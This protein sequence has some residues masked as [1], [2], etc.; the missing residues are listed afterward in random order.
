MPPLPADAYA[1]ISGGIGVCDATAGCG[2]IKSLFR[3]WRRYNTS[4]PV[5]AIGSEMEGI[6]W[7][8]GTAVRAPWVVDSGG[9]QARPVAGVPAPCETKC[10]S[11][12]RLPPR[13]RSVA[14]PDPYLSSVHGDP[15]GRNIPGR[16]M[17]A[18]ENWPAR[19]PLSPTPSRDEIDERRSRVLK[20]RPRGRLCWAAVLGVPAYRR[21]RRWQ[22]AWLCQPP[23]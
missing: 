20:R 5:I 22:S 11:W 16:T 3:A 18:T 21:S 2:A 7:P 15:S 17:R 10:R 19:P 9:A 14:V 1:R 12:C 13:W 8:P 4:I 6:G 23:P